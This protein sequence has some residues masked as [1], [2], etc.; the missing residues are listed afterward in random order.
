[1]TIEKEKVIPL[2]E[3]S[4]DQSLIQGVYGKYRIT[5][6]DEIEVQRY[7]ISILIC[8]ISFCGGIFHWLFFGPSLAWLWLIAMTVGLGL[9][10]KWIHIYLRPLHR[11]LQILWAIGCLGFGILFINVGGQNLLSSLASKPIWTIAIGPLFAALTGIGFKEFFCFRR[12][13]A[14][15][16]TILVPLALLGHLIGVLQ[17]GLVMI[18]LI[19]SAILLLVLSIR[20][21]G[22]DAAADVGDKSV[23]NYLD[24][25][26][27]AE[28]L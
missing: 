17:P 16:L 11:A 21:F 15:G 18:L 26:Q 6:D 27:T 5:K 14:I 28:A 23:F 13:E 19:C 12:L 4:S 3:P 20:K 22:M 8:G 2:D 10:L 24:R 7:R 25:Q 1:M 9:A